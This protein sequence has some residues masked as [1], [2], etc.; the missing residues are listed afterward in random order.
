VSV[1]KDKDSAAPF[2]SPIR[3]PVR[4]D[5]ALSVRSLCPFCGSSQDPDAE[6]CCGDWAAN[7]ICVDAGAAPEGPPRFVRGLVAFAVRLN[8]ASQ[9]LVMLIATSTVAMLVSLAMQSR[10]LAE[11][12]VF[13]ATIIRVGMSPIALPQAITKLVPEP[14]VSAAAASEAAA[15]PPHDAPQ[16]V[17]ASLPPPI[18]RAAVPAP[19]PSRDIVGPQMPTS[20]LRTGWSS[21]DVSRWQGLRRGMSRNAVRM[22]LGYPRWVDRHT[23]PNTEYWLYEGDRLADGGWIAFFDNDGPVADWRRP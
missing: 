18:P 6:P 2:E 14:P 5:H 7:S 1:T 23:T 10:S 16:V 20:N 15:S 8:E 4:S 21:G 17:V 22:L 19:L 12:A 3:T 13:D 9:L 11:Q